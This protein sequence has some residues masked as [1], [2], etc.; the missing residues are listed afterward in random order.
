MPNSF[1]PRIHAKI[2]EQS[3]K[4]FFQRYIRIEINCSVD[5]CVAMS[6]QATI[7]RRM[8]G[9]QNSTLVE[10]LTEDHLVMKPL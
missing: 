7:A 1:Y 9:W 5:V 6:P 2:Y 4:L 8:K 10:E 3:C